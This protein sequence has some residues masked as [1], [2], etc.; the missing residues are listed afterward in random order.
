MLR[1]VFLLFSLH[2][3]F[4]TFTQ[5]SRVDVLPKSLL[6]LG[7]SYQRMDIFSGLTFQRNFSC[8]D[9]GVSFSLGTRTSFGGQQFYPQW[10]TYVAL[11]IGK[12]LG[13]SSTFSIGPMAGF[14]A[15][16]LKVGNKLYQYDFMFGYSFYG[17]KNKSRLQFFH[18]VGLGPFAEYFRGLANSQVQSYALAY[19]IKIALA[20]AFR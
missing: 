16:F 12:L 18:Q 19:H 17:G 15:A 3:C 7:A 20:Y 10:G 11:P 1:F 8:F 2:N 5:V 14:N 4:F 13:K 6:L 9:M